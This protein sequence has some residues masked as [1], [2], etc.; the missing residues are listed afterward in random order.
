[1]HIDRLFS[2]CS[3]FNTYVPIQEVLPETS[4][5][6]RYKASEVDG[7]SSQLSGLGDPGPYSLLSRQEK[8]LIE[9]LF[10]YLYI[11]FVF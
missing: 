4:M 7:L 10:N 1:M 11:G 2:R 8:R 6:T 9:K 5:L 3:S